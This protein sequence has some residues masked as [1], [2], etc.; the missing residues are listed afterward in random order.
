MK[1][2]TKA[3]AQNWWMFLLIA[4]PILLGVLL[5]ASRMRFWMGV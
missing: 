3:R 2:E 5:I 1:D 4:V